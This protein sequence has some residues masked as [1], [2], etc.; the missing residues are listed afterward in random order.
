M[1]DE[2]LVALAKLIARHSTLINLVSLQLADQACALV[3][4]LARCG[5]CD[6]DPI[7]VEH[8][9]T[10]IQACDRCAAE[11]IVASGRTYVDAYVANPDDPLNEA[12]YSLMNEDN[13]VDLPDAQKIRRIVDYVRII[14]Q[15]EAPEGGLH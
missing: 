10:G 12:R 15:S 1:Q 11:M 9:H 8:R 13:W 7:T 14:K 6:S 4:C 2:E 3:P 5:R